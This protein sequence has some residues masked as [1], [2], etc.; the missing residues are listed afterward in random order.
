MF[1]AVLLSTLLHG[2]E[3]NETED[4]TDV[5]FKDPTKSLLR[6]RHLTHWRSHWWH[7]SYWTISQTAVPDCYYTCEPYAHT[8]KPCAIVQLQTIRP[9][10][11]KWWS[12]KLSSR[13]NELRGAL[14]HQRLRGEERRGEVWLTLLKPEV[15]TTHCSSKDQRKTN[16]K[17]TVVGV[18][19]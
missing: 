11:R 19:Y 10:L 12:L 18:D 4:W 13:E 9:D 2:V 17:K 15:G 6:R 1:L 7:C 14:W 16:N 8:T 3:V 5:L